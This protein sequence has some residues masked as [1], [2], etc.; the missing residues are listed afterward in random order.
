MKLGKWFVYIFC[1]LILVP[2]C[3]KKQEEAVVPESA[4]QQLAVQTVDFATTGSISGKVLFEGVVPPRKEL[5]VK[6]NPE[7]SVINHG[8]ILS[9]ELLSKDGTL[10][11]VFVYVKQG[12]E[13]YK[14]DPP[15]DSVEIDN[16]KCVYVPHVTGVQAG[17]P[18]KFLNNDPTLHNI[19][20]FAKNQPGF[21]MG[22]PFQGMKQMKKFNTP[23]VMVSLKCDV[24]PWMQGYIG[25]LPHPYFAVTGDDG[26]FTIKN[27]PPGNYVLEAWHETLGTKEL[28]VTVGPQESKE[29]EFSFKSTGAPV[30]GHQ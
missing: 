13:N 29:V 28:P 22:L 2:G 7:C 9:E 5:P 26:S 3:G 1:V 24:H 21:N 15:A 16:S 14:F 20:A 17:Q 8:Q 4:S 18:V 6:G 10:Q 30:T 25:V 12:L 11:N 27:L 23:E 19:H